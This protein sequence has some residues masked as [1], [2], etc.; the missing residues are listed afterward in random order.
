MLCD[1]MKTSHNVGLGFIPHVSI[2]AMPKT[3]HVFLGVRGRQWQWYHM[4]KHMLNQSSSQ[5]KT[6]FHQMGL[7]GQTSTYF[8]TLVQTNG[9]IMKRSNMVRHT[10]HLNRSKNGWCSGFPRHCIHITVVSHSTKQ[11]LFGRGSGRSR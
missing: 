9:H 10:G 7:I 1:H 6:V 8:G 5:T 3:L 11:G 4:G 2:F